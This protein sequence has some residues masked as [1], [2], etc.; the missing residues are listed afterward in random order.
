MSPCAA[1]RAAPLLQVTRRTP[2]R[3]ITPNPQLVAIR[4]HDAPA[5][6]TVMLPPGAP[7]A[8]VKLQQR[9]TSPSTNHI[10]LQGQ[11]QHAIWAEKALTAA[12]QC[13]FVIAALGLWI[14]ASYVASLYVG[15]ALRGDFEAWNQV[16][17]RGYKP[18]DT[19]GNLAVGTHLFV[20]VVI[21]AAGPVQLIPWIRARFPL[22]HRIN[23]RVFLVGACLASLA[24]LYL[25][26]IRG[27]TTGGLVSHLGITLDAVLIL[28][29]AALAV[30]YAMLGKF[31][32]HRRWALRLFLVVNAVWF[33]RIG[34]MFWLFIHQAP[35]GF[36]PQTFTG[37]F[38]D[39]MAFAQ[40]LLPLAILELYLR[41]KD[42]GSVAAKLA[43]AGGLL[44][45]TAGMATGI[46]AATM[47]MWLPL[48]GVR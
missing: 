34:L 25:V 11:S 36:D 37:P 38:L 45:V 14:F 48:M 32:I 20:A 15:S 41:A 19:L 7:V 5:A 46:F 4:L 24:G 3:L 47:G 8:R 28:A 2:L 10:A 27:G 6:S 35:V 22:F 29:F 18:G 30:R 43:T 16:F 17:P 44:V 12:A 42:A 39:V 13:W 40:T 9:A 21:I 33:F 23:G 26:W 31:S 1:V